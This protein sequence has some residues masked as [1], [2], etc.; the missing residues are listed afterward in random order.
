MCII[1]VSVDVIYK[2]SCLDGFKYIG[3]IVYIVYSCIMY[4]CLCL[5][6]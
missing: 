5:F 3:D 2:Y 6:I 1:G 4:I